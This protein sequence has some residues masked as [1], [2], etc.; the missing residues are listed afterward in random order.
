MVDLGWVVIWVRWGV[1]HGGIPW[2]GDGWHEKS[3]N[4]DSKYHS[5]SHNRAI[6]DRYMGHIYG[7]HVDHT[8][9]NLG[10][11][12]FTGGELE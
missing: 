11:R 3:Q 8:Q 1:D 9:I 12:V 10:C 6:T 2:L 7:S 4:K 5:L